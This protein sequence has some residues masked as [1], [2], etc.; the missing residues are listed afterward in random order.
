MSFRQSPCAWPADYAGCDVP[1]TFANLPA[2]GKAVY[3][4][5]ATD[6]LWNFTGQRFGVCEVTVRPCRQDCRDAASTFYGAGGGAGFQPVIVGGQWYNLGCGSC[7]DDCSCDSVS[8]LRLPGP[9]TAITEVQIDG[10]VVD[11]ATY[12]VDNSRLLVNEG[13]SWPV[14]QDMGAPLGEVGTWAVT[15]ERGIEV[16][17]GGRV[18]AG[19]LAVELWKALCN[20]E[21][22]RLPQRI[23]VLS[24]QGVSIEPI[25]TEMADLEKGFTGIWVIDQWLA[26]VTSAASARSR[27]KV[28]SPD[29]PRG[30]ARQRRTT[31]RI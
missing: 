2:S 29:L 1:E 22:C 21:S 19:T 9:V 17:T 23:K 31:W 6:Y 11:P 3:E 14:C 30:G 8:I 24:R 26:S 5:M 7:G 27:P 25:I 4:E 20:D 13:A 12:R 15:Y 28:L 18:A 10:E 16:P